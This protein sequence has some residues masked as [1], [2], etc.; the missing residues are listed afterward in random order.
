M[1]GAGITPEGLSAFR[2]LPVAILGLAVV[3]AIATAASY[4]VLRRVGRLAPLEAFFGSVPGHFSLVM[5]L[6]VERGARVEQ[7][8]VPQVTRLLILVA[9]VP[10]ILGGQ[11]SSTIRAPS[12]AAS[13]TAD[14]A[15]T[16]AIAVASSLLAVRLRIPAPV[17]LGPMITSAVLSGTGLVVIAVPEWLAAVAFT[18][19]GA[20][21]GARFAGVRRDGLR[22]MAIAALASFV[23]AFSAAMAASIVVAAL[24]ERPL[25]AVFLGY[26]PGGLEAMIALSFLLGYDVAFVAVLHTARMILL[27]VAIPLAATAIQRR[28]RPENLAAR[29]GATD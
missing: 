22:R 9:I 3:V 4:A 29:H 21:I 25:G 18:V 24:I 8:L 2:T 17:I 27:S 26:A 13:T 20:S 14:F 10:F 5:A 19:L 23:A 15:L 7:V 11:G 1:M 6:C 28:T 12:A 16:M